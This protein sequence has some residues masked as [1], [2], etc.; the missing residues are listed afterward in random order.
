[1]STKG[2]TQRMLGFGLIETI[3]A[4]GIFSI[5]VVTGVTTVLHSL[6]VNRLTAEENDALLYAQEG[7]EAVRAIR[8]QSWSSLTVGT[9]GLSSEGGSWAFAGTSDSKDNMTRT[10]VLTSPGVSTFSATVNINWNFT[11]TRNNQ[12]SLQ[13]TF[14][15][16]RQPLGGIN[17]CAQYCQSL[18]TYSTGQCRATTAQCVSNG[19]VYES[20]GD[21]YCPG[22]PAVDTCCCKI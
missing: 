9:Y 19:E 6:A 12:I 1:M 15:N 16:W 18:I 17:S 11:P 13:D 4:L 7:L 10:V 22:T 20:G 5:M 8:D 21:T 14:T 2:F 3:V